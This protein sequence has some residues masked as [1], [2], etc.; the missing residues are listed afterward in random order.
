MKIEI[1]KYK[2]MCLRLLEILKKN[3]IAVPAGFKVEEGGAVTGLKD[4]DKNKDIFD[5]NAMSQGGGSQADPNE[6]QDDKENMDGLNEGGAGSGQ[7]AKELLEMKD[8]M[9]EQMVKMTIELKEKNERLIEQLEEMEDL[10][11]Q[12][13]ARDKSISL[14]QKQIESLLEELRDAKAIEN[15]IKLL[16]HKKILLEEENGRLRHEIN[17][18]FVHNTNSAYE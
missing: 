4:D 17:T 18:K 14:Q 8:R 1:K 3:G 5:I 10:R 11:I 15:D 9:E 16:V 6:F 12:V 7:T 2:N 13:Y